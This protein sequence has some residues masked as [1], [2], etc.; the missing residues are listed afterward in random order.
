MGFPPPGGLHRVI[1]APT[2]G[3]SAACV[4]ELGGFRAVVGGV[5]ES[6]GVEEE[7]SR[8]SAEGWEKQYPKLDLGKC[9]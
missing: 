2:R 4:R 6:A 9:S 3:V 1:V 5:I 8:M 7:W